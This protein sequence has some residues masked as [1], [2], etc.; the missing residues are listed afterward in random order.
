[1]KA[2]RALQASTQARLQYSQFR[3]RALQSGE[4]LEKLPDELLSQILCHAS[5][6]FEARD[7]H[8]NDVH[9]TTPAMHDVLALSHVNRRFFHVARGTQELWTTITQ[10]QP[11]D[12]VQAFLDRSGG[13]GLKVVQI[14]NAFVEEDFAEFYRT[15]KTVCQHASRLE[16]LDLPVH[17]A[18]QE[19]AVYWII[20]DDPDLRFPRL[21]KLS[22]S[23]P[24][25]GKVTPI[26]P[27]ERSYGSLL[28]ARLPSLCEL[29]VPDYM[30]NVCAVRT[31]TS[32]YL[33][34]A[35]GPSGDEFVFSVDTLLAA[36]AELPVLHSFSLS[37]DY[38][39]AD[40]ILHHDEDLPDVVLS[41]VEHLTLCTATEPAN[42]VV[43]N[44]LQHARFP[45][46]KSLTLE[47]SS[48]FRSQGYEPD[49]I[50]NVVRALGERQELFL[51]LHTLNL[52]R[53][54]VLEAELSDIAYLHALNSEVDQRMFQRMPA[55][56][57]ISLSKTIPERTLRWLGVDPMDSTCLLPHL[58]C[59][60][61]CDC[62]YVLGEEI[63][64]ALT[65]RN[66]ASPAKPL[67]KLV[68]KGCSKID[69]YQYGRFLKE[70]HGPG[71]LD[72]DYYDLVHCNKVRMGD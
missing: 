27:D 4:G 31:L 69:V 61:L 14:P 18:W 67:K 13:R 53:A 15:L 39:D 8:S 20:L 72:V 44:I 12:M 9:T 2:L 50:H 58:E 43:A 11:F 17:Y 1:M 16:V 63:M 40:A 35:E 49:G 59:I 56:R 62:D 70:M 25:Y 24:Y 65:S 42:Y 66:C 5:H 51:H 33:V 68:V 3:C 19:E 32:L 34:G 64:R 48:Y 28:G 71:S 41:N 26:D 23:C 7:A 21:A 52:T 54:P 46:L 45:S 6:P 55:L 30:M 37:L 57:N 38:D 60:S 29:N 36:L 47:L 22:V 10:L